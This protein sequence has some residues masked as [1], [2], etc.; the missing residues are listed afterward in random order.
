MRRAL[1]FAMVFTAPIPLALILDA[2]G[3]DAAKRL[4]VVDVAATD[5]KGEPVTDLKS[6]DVQLREDGKPRTL[7]Y[8]H[9]N[10][11][12][13]EMLTPAAGEVANRAA[14][15][16]TVILFDRWNETLTTTANAWNSLDTYLDHAETI[17]RL[18]IYFLTNHGE[19]YPVRPLPTGSKAPGPTPTAAELRASLDDVV[20]KLTGLRDA[21]N[22]DPTVRINTTI[23]AL[24]ALGGQLASVPGRKNLIWVTHGFPLQFRFTGELLDATPE[25]RKLSALAVQSEIA[26]YDVDESAQ[27]AGANLIGQ[28]RL[29]LQMFSSL[30]GGRWY[31][32]EEVASALNGTSVDGRGAYRLAYYSDVREKDRKEHKIRLDSS[33]SGVRL[34]AREGYFGDAPESDPAVIEKSQVGVAIRSAFDASDI[35]LRASQSNGHVTVHV[36]PSSVLIDHAGDSY[37]GR[38]S[39]MLAY[40]SDD[41]FG[42][43]NPAPVDIRLNAD[44]YEK[45]LKEGIVVEQDLRIDDRMRRIRA[46]VF[47]Q[48][49][50][51]LGSVTIPVR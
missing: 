28:G 6:T 40:Y 3:S 46:I 33:R 39:L 2:A 27:G 30:T 7:S 22:Q 13:R 50:R 29:T 49:L 26:F 11:S 51:T 45:A 12:R 20:R 14:P 43:T 23:Q 17:D 32:S 48:N 25:V 37:T 36:D 1:C 38:L 8:F 9:F 47:D 44:Q 35:A 16:V 31:A 15:P 24:T 42:Q 10:G 19:L 4:I 18:Y 34:L 41:A 21:R 5:S